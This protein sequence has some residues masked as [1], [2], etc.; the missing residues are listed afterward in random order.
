MESEEEPVPVESWSCGGDGKA[1]KLWKSD[2]IVRGMALDLQLRSWLWAILCLSLPAGAVSRW[3]TGEPMDSA[4]A[5]GVP[6]E[7]EHPDM[8]FEFLW[9]G[10][11]LDTMGQFHL[12]DEELASTR[13]GRRL[14]LFF[15]H[16][17][18][19]TLAGTEQ[20]LRQWHQAAPLSPANFQQLLLTSVACVYRL[21]AALEGEERAHWAELFSLLG[22]EIL[23]D[24]CKDHCP[25]GQIP[26]LSPWAFPNDPSQQH[27]SP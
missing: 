12:R 2:S 5:G 21:H 14:T 4:G 10:L 7:P 20:Q 8:M 9:T 27:S 23:Q 1:R 26:L 17:V 15:Q 11:K 3:H 16:W 24:L 25:Q 19:S 22:Q 13:P 6:L 18:P